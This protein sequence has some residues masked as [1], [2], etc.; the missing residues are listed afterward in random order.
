LLTSAVDISRLFVKD[1]VIV[2][3]EDKDGL[4]AWADQKAD[5]AKAGLADVSTVVLINQ[6]SAS[7]SEIV[8]GCL[9]AHGAAVIVGERSF[10]KGSVQ[11]V[12]QTANNARLKLTTQYYRLPDTVGPNGEAIRGRLVH[13]RPGQRVWGV[14]P[15]ITVKMSPK[16][17]EDSLNLRQDADILPQDGAGK[18]LPDSPDR[19]EVSRLVV[20]GLDPQLETALL[21]LQAR[22]LGTVSDDTKHA[23]RN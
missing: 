10:G 14:D 16:Q 9:Q 7:A 20:E 22:A 13:K 4:K 1:G 11:T 6:G 15:D 2:S 3:G 23:S 19:P 18:L 17:I 21:L 5:P 8:A 12:H